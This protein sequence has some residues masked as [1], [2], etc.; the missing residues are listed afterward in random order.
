MNNELIAGGAVAAL[1]NEREL[2]LNIGRDAGVAEGMRF[3]VLEKSKVIVDPHT[4]GELGTLQREKVRV[5][6]IEVHPKFS[7]ARTYETYQF[8]PAPAMDFRR[9]F[10]WERA[11]ENF[12]RYSISAP[13]KSQ[14]RVRTLK[15][16]DRP[17]GF[18]PI[19]EAGSYVEV[20]DP[21]VLVEAAEV[22]TPKAEQPQRSK[23]AG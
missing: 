3:R 16:S 18:D 19:S 17:A 5:K 13:E 23:V 7:I 2:A 1:L 12:A 8:E 22:E 10:A 6:V 15:N 20:G 4:K 11:L 14:T 21:I 9:Q